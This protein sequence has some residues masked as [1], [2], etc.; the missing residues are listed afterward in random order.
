MSGIIN[1]LPPGYADLNTDEQNGRV[2]RTPSGPRI[3]AYA[4]FS[5]FVIAS[6]IARVLSYR[7]DRDRLLSI[8]RSRL[9]GDIAVGVTTVLYFVVTGLQ[10]SLLVRDL[11]RAK[12]YV[13][14]SDMGPPVS[15]HILYLKVSETLR[16]ASAG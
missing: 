15:E 7:G 11:F 8:P 1:D 16:Y 12:N 2:S 13:D 14:N 9:C 3:V 4:T 10:V 5:V 6:L